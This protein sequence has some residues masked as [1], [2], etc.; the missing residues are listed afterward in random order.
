M[1]N[2]NCQNMPIQQEGKIQP[3]INDIVNASKSDIHLA[4]LL[5][6]A[7]E[8]AHVYLLAKQTYKGFE[9]MGEVATLREELKDTVDKMIRYCREKNGMSIACSFDPDSTAKELVKTAGK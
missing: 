4:G 8:C 6:E 5:D 3:M 9:N 2:N 7:R 1:K